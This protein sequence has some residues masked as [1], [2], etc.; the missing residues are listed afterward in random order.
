MRVN[1]LLFSQDTIEKMAMSAM[2]PQR[3]LLLLICS[4]KKIIYPRKQRINT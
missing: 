4:L 3:F 1:L 2:T